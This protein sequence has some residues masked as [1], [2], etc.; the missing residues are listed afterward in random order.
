MGHNGAGKTNILDAVY[1]TSMCRSFLNPI[2]SQNIAFDEQ[3]FIIQSIWTK[4]NNDTEIYCGVKRG[5]KKIF[6]KNIDLFNS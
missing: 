3:F 1:Y 5:Q 4:N 6:K 2:D